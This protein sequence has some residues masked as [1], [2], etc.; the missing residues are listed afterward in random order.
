MGYVNSKY[1]VKYWILVQISKCIKFKGGKIWLI[2]LLKWSKKRK[3]NKIKKKRFSL[4]INVWNEK[5]VILI[6]PTFN[7]DF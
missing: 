4:L 1:L 2:N 5:C 7:K 6:W 3:L